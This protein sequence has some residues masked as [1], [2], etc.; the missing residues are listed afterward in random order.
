MHTQ[1][2]FRGLSNEIKNLGGT[3]IFLGTEKIYIF[4]LSKVLESLDFISSFI[5]YVFCNIEMLMDWDF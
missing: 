4:T 5:Q 2:I 3:H 1:D